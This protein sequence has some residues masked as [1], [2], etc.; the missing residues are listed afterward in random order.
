[1]SNENNRE[2]KVES[3]ENQQKRIIRLQALR[4]KYILYWSENN[5]KKKKKNGN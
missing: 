5:A 2:E 1:M 3:R 4:M